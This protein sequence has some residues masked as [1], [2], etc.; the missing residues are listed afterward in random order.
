MY[1]LIAKD[2]KMF[3]VFPGKKKNTN[4]N[5]QSEFGRFA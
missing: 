1:T 4:K 2:F 5:L 3:N